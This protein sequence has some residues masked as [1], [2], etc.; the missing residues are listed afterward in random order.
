MLQP[1]VQAAQAGQQL[2]DV[3]QLLVL[4][5]RLLLEQLARR[6]HAEQVHCTHTRTGKSPALTPA[7]TADGTY[8]RHRA[9]CRRR[10]FMAVRYAENR[11]LFRS[12]GEQSRTTLQSVEP[13]SCWTGTG[14]SSGGLATPRRHAGGGVCRGRSLTHPETGTAPPSWGGPSMWSGSDGCRETPPLIHHR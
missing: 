4:L 7:P 8:L 3:Q 14:G 5:Q 6:L 11:T 10:S 13:T 2:G 12:A 9:F 1:L